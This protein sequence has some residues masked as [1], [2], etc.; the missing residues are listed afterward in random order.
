V[1]KKVIEA[2]SGDIKQVLTDALK[3]GAVAGKV[4]ENFGIEKYLVELFR[5]LFIESGEA[6][7]KKIKADALNMRE[8]KV[9]EHDFFL[10]ATGQSES[11]LMRS[12]S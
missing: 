10:I 7:Y 5:S 4:K 12:N 3:S 8:L 1:L 11:L 6:K 9:A 2:G